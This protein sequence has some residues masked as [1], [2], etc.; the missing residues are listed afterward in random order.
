MPSTG[1]CDACAIAAFSSGPAT[2][3]RFRLLAAVPELDPAPVREDQ[4]RQDPSWRPTYV[5]A[6]TV[7]KDNPAFLRGER[8]GEGILFSP[9]RPRLRVDF[10]LEHEPPLRREQPRGRRGGGSSRRPRSRSSSSAAAPAQPVYVEFI[11]LLKETFRSPV[12]HPIHCPNGGLLSPDHWRRAMEAG[13]YSNLMTHFI[14]GYSGGLPSRST[15]RSERSG[16][17]KSRLPLW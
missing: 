17:S 11:F 12:L 2:P 1:C 10:L 3:P 6:G 16:P 4:E 9:A 15:M 13:A 5:L 14:L 8:N 7:A